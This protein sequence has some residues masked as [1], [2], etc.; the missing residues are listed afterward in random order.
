MIEVDKNELAEALNALGKL[1]CRT[2][3]L[4]S[5]K[6]IKIEIA[7]GKLRRERS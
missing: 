7:K 4:A 1:I 6:S 2:S 3:P 5:Y